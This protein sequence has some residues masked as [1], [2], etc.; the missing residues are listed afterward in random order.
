[1]GSHP[2]MKLQLAKIHAA[3]AA[4]PPGYVQDVLSRGVVQGDA[5]EISAEQMEI[6]RQ[7]YRHHGKV[8]GLG[9]A[10]AIIAQPI[11]RAIDAVAGTHIQTCGGC[12]K[13]RSALN[14]ILPFR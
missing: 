8:K 5:L 14:R 12:A 4:R 3:A 1:M 7:K 11:A 9:D 2:A 13:R 6:L 10:V